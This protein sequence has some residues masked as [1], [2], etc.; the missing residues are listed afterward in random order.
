MANLDDTSFTS[1]ALGG[2]GRLFFK[3]FGFSA[4]DNE[5]TISVLIFVELFELGKRSVYKAKTT[6]R[7]QKN[8]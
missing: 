5:V 7:K 2:E 1:N 4:A 8:K 3:S 6:K